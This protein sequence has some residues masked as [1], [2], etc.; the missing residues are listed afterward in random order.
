MLPKFASLLVF[1]HDSA[2]FR[3]PFIKAKCPQTP[4]YFPAIRM[5]YKCLE[6]SATLKLFFSKFLKF[7]HDSFGK[8]T[9]HLIK[10]H[11]F[12]K[13]FLLLVQSVE[14]SVLFHKKKK[15]A[16]KLEVCDIYY[17]TC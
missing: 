4:G 13:P 7:F 10:K 8:K 2:I 14:A 9:E 11:V 6:K 16:L 12:K 5:Y 1:K 17:V 3:M 15:N